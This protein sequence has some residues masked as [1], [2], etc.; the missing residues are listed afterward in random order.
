MSKIKQNLISVYLEPSELKGVDSKSDIWVEREDFYCAGDGGKSTKSRGKSIEN[1]PYLIL[2]FDT[3]FKSPDQSVTP[4]Q[5]KS[6]D[7]KYKVL[8]YQF[9]AKFPM[10]RNG[11]EF[12]VQRMMKG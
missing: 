5:I 10:D 2:G 12:V 8:S 4:D 6:G 1:I 11:V 9:H 7:A 3:E